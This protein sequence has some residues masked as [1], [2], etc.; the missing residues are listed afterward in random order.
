[1]VAIY[2]EGRTVSLSRYFMSTVAAW[3]RAARRVKPAPITSTAALAM[4]VL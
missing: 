1:M 4:K 3:A 2:Q